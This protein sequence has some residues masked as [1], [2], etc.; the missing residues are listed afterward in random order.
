MNFGW[1]HDPAEVERIWGTMPTPFFMAPS[2]DQTRDH[3]NHKF[4]KEFVGEDAPAGPQAIGDCVSWGNGNLVNYTSVLE[5]YLEVKSGK[6]DTG[7]EYQETCTEAIYAL[8]RVEVGGQRGSYSDGSVGA[9]AAKA[10]TQFGT[11]SRKHLEKLGL[12]GAYSGQRAKEW[13]ARGL[14][15]NLEPAAREHLIT[16][17]TPVRSFLDAAWH[18]QNYRV[19][20]VCSNVGFENGR[21]R[22]AITER[23]SQGFATARGTWPHCMLFVSVRWDRPGL[24]ML[25]Q[26]PKSSVAGPLVHDQPPVS[27]WVDADTV[28]RMLRQNDSYTG[29]KH[30]GYPARR[31]TWRT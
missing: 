2:P 29:T 7:Y 15:D 17:M 25:N 21:G 22:G 30:K 31:L 26:W 11:L 3:F 10:V 6:M 28:D 12:S 8:S 27:W 1:Q 14:P 24:L 19:V 18:I 13:G 20:A 4:F 16:D 5:A 9:W 23:D